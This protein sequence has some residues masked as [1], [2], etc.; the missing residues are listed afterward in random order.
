MSNA[1][2]I[3]I[4]ESADLPALAELYRHLNPDDA[5]IAPATAS[6]NF[7][8]FQKYP[9]SAIYL[10]EDGGH[11]VASCTLVVVP[12][13]TRAGAPYALIENV[14]THGDFRGRGF[15]KAVLR[16]A[17]SDA[18]LQDCYKVM[19]LTGSKKP[20]TLKFYADIGFEQNKTGFQIRRIPVRDDN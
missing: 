2:R 6:A 20:S 5:V 11:L 10:L 8:R 14:V 15:G 9:G 1:P 18:W 19:L 12:N 7:A 3:R 16:A 17:L 4:A 13:L